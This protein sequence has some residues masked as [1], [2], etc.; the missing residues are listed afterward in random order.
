MGQLGDEA[1]DESGEGADAAVA[2]DV[3]RALACLAQLAPAQR[4][5][6]SLAYLRECSHSQVAGRLGMPLGT[7]KARIRSGL[8]NL[9][10]L[11][12]A[13]VA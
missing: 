4:Q 12:E 5:A 6:I 9:K 1:A 11:I 8:V 2:V 7:V 3:K 13:P 10:Q